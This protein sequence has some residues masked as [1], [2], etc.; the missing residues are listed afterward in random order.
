MTVKVEKKVTLYLL[1]FIMVFSVISGTMVSSVV[2]AD[3]VAFKEVFDNEP[4]APK[5]TGGDWIIENTNNGTAEIS[6]DP[7]TV[8]PNN[9]SLKLTDTNLVP[10]NEYLPSATA[11]RT[12]S[13]QTGIFTVETKIRIKKLETENQHFNIVLYDNSS[14]VAVKLTYSVGSWKYLPASGLP[15]ITLPSANFLGEW[16]TIR[17]KFNM[18]EGK[19]D[20]TVISGAYNGIFADGTFNVKGLDI[21]AGINNV[22][23]VRYFP[24]NYKGEYYIDHIALNNAAPV[25]TNGALTVSEQ[26]ATSAKLTWSGASDDSGSIAKYNIYDGTALIDTAAGTANTKTLTNLS[27]GKHAFRIEAEDAL[28]NQSS[29]GPNATME[30]K[31]PT[32]SDTFDFEPTAA[33]TNGGGWLVDTAYGKVEIFDDHTTTYPGNKSMKLTDTDH[34]T[35]QEYRVGGAA[36]RTFSAQ[37]G[38]F[39]LETKVRIQQHETANQ[40]FNIVFQN[41]S[42]TVVLKLVY[43]G[44]GWSYYTVPNPTANDISYMPAANMLGQWMTVKVTFDMHLRKY[45][46]TVTSDALKTSTSTDTRLNKSTGVFTVTGQ[47]IQT[48][49][50]EVSKVNYFAQNYKGA[51]YIDY[52]TLADVRPTAMFPAPPSE[53]PRLYFRA[54]DI[55]S[56]NAKMAKTGMGAYWGTVTSLSSLS[57]SAGHLPARPAANNNNFDESI[58]NIIKAKALV[59]VLGDNETL[60]REAINMLKNFLTDLSFKENNSD[61]VVVTGI[62][63]N[64]A[65]MVYDWSYKYLTQAEKTDLVAKF[66]NL[67]VNY[68]TLSFPPQAGSAITGHRSGSTIL[69]DFL[70]AGVAIY[71]EKQDMYKVT[72]KLVMDDFAPARDVLYNSGMPYQGDSYGQLRYG[73]ETSANLI[74]AGMGYPDAFDKNLGDV[75]YRILYTRRPDNDLLRDGDAYLIPNRGGHTY[76]PSTFLNSA[77][78]YKNGYFKNEFLREYAQDQYKVDPILVPLFFDPDLQSKPL[79]ELPLSRY[80]GSPVGSMVARTGWNLAANSSDVV[81]EMKVSEYHFNNHNQMDTGAFQLYYKGMLALDSGAYNDYD[82]DHDRNY[83]R[84]T[85]AHNSML[86][87]KENDT[88]TRWGVPVSNDGGVK[89]P[90]RGEEATNINEVLT[91]GYKMSE[92]GGHQFGPDPKTPDYTYLKGNLTNAYLDRVSKYTRSFVFLNLKNSNINSIHPAAMIVYDKVISKDPTYKKYWL[93]HSEQEPTIGGVDNNVTTITRNLT[94]YSS[95]NGKLVNTTLQPSST[96]LTIE[97][98]G[99]PGQEFSVFGTN[100]PLTLPLPRKTGLDAGAWRVQI[101]PKS[102]QTDDNFLNVIQVMDNNGTVPLA[103]TR[104]D[105]GVMEGAKIADRVVMFSKSGDRLKGSITLPDIGQETTSFKYVVTDVAAGYWKVQKKGQSTWSSPITVSEEGGALSFNGPAE[106]HTLTWSATPF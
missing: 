41:N 14:N 76:L 59:S 86:I 103:V 83:F 45:D 55:P 84:R 49:I 4:T 105:A 43:S 13:A 65:A 3:G 75:P 98:V 58:L 78:F 71:D 17:M 42:S 2:R 8:N 60:G 32:F 25:W 66:E 70:S 30:N 52:L 57:G 102:P 12:F 9:K 18:S 99:G 36:T 44:N 28:G 104:I 39:T 21:P 5:V 64:G 88:F 100:Y 51:Y 72:A 46:M 6:V 106:E 61:N 37:T 91:N 89:W 48:G 69:K 1:S 10:G 23:K 53:H 77:G 101:S 85:I 22:S 31:R 80:F 54:K 68:T 11:T 92:I 24:Q 33:K 35:G 87:Y 96:N 16:V 29:G 38:K 67:A 62:V 97:K 94:S 15:E 27:L 73:F 26:T 34:V 81:A 7:T 63:L 79:S 74:F 56:L 93:L 90:N 19:Y 20:L 47:D 82:D 95:Y 50:S 40:H